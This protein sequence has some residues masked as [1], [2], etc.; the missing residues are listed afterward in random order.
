MDLGYTR[1]DETVPTRL[2]ITT[3]MNNTISHTLEVLVCLQKN[4]F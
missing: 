1:I 3:E 2:F 4:A